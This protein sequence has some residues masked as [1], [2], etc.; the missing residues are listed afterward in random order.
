MLYEIPV[1]IRVFKINRQITAH[2]IYD[3]LLIRLNN[4]TILHQKIT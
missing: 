4:S 3:W 2:I 1:V